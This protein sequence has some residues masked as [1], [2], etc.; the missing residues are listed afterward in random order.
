M[1]ET[2]PPPP[3]PGP[4]D[5]RAIQET[6]DF[7]D[8]RRRL[9]RFVF[10]MTALFLAWYLLYVLVADFAHDFM[11]IKLIGNINLGLIFGLLQFVSTFAITMLYV[12]F[13]NRRLD[14]LADR[15]R[16]EAEGGGR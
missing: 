10:P 4:D 7:V 9:R 8:L 2:P 14:P 13:A 5:W 11:S 15:I 3:P 1:S 6:P 16:E 12:R